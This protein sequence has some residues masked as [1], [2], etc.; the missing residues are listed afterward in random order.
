MNKAIKLTSS[1]CNAA[2]TVPKFIQPAAKLLLYTRMA[3]LTSY[4]RP[5]ERGGGGRGTPL[6]K[7]YKYAP[8]Q[9]K[10][11]NFLFYMIITLFRKLDLK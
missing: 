3:A 7:L 11:G 5:R 2:F 8:S 10:S 6:Y 4:L 1:L 9:Q